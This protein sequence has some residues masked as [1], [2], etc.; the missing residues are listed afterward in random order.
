MTQESIDGLYRSHAFVV[1]RRCRQLLQDADEARDAMH[2]TFLKFIEDPSA[3]RG[4]SSPATFLFGV[5]T[6]LCLNRIRNRA[7]RDAAWQEN[8][9]R[10]VQGG[11]AGL[12]DAAEA[13]SIAAA[14]LSRVDEESATIALYHFVDGLSQGE[15]AKLVGRSRVTVNQKLQR[16]RREAQLA[17]E[18]R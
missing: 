6:H 10:A 7:A 3:F 14:L 12:H 11:Q 9:A 1:F 4:S 5:A 13:R 18:S 2:E 15:I 17:L 16:F 8:V